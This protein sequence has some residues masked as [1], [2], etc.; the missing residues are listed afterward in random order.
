MNPIIL[1]TDA[2]VLNTLANHPR[3]RPVIGPLNDQ[4][5][6]DQRFEPNWVTRTRFFHNEA[7]TIGMLFDWTKPRVWELHTMA[8]PEARG[9]EAFQ[10]AI[11]VIAEMFATEADE[12]WG[13]TPVANEIARAMHRKIGGI[14]HGFGIHPAIGPVEIFVTPRADWK[15]FAE[16][17]GINTSVTKS[18]NS[19]VTNG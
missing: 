3:I 4:L 14:S 9:G 1:A 7:E 17:S 10:F 8:T 2:R 15:P 13:Q 6:F 12:I 16:G 18:I 11:D 19:E 5:A